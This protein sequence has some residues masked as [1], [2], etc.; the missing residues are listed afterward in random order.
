LYLRNRSLSLCFEYGRDDIE[1]GPGVCVEIAGRLFVAT[2]AH[3]FA[4][5][6]PGVVWSAFGANRSSK[7]PLNVLQANHRVGIGNNEPDVAWLEID[8]QSAK[9]S[10][11]VAV[12]LQDV[13]LYPTLYPGEVYFATGFPVSLKQVSEAEGHRE[14]TLPFGIYGTTAVDDAVASNAGALI[15]LEY[16]KQGI[17]INGNQVEVEPHGVSGGGIWY[18]PKQEAVPKQVWEPGRLKLLALSKAYLRRSH[19]VASEPMHIW[20]TLVRNDIPEL[21]DIIDP[22][23]Q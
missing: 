16:P 23:L 13:L 11:L 4:R 14:I 8:P 6:A 22:L 1:A 5:L 3:N 17:D 12:P 21:R 9:D 10:D 7:H 19:Q 20:L 18:C 2:A 15:V